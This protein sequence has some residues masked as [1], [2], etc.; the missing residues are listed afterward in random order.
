MRVIQYYFSFI[1][2]SLQQTQ[3]SQKKKRILKNVILIEKKHTWNSSVRRLRP[4]MFHVLGLTIVPDTLNRSA[5]LVTSDVLG[6]YKQ[7]SLLTVIWKYSVTMV[8][9]MGG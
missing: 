7:F 1:P 5:C 3:S 8:E 2:F 6:K 4:Y 9:E